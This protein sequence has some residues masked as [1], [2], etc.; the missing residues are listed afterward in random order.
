MR[1]MEASTVSAQPSGSLRGWLPQGGSLPAAEW[2]RR[3]RALLGCLWLSA[4][5]ITLYGAVSSGYDAV[6]ALAHAAGPL[7]LAAAASITR[8]GRTARAACVSVGLLTVAAL[9]VHLTG[10][11]I[12]AH[13]MFFVVIVALT[14]YEDWLPF[15]L[16][17][18]YV[19]VHH[20]ALGTA[21]PQ[22]VYN[23]PEAWQDPWGWAGI[24]ALFV[25]MAGAA[26]IVAWRLN[27]SVRSRMR[28]TQHELAILSETD[29]LTHLANRRRAMID[30]ERAFAPGAPESSILVL[31]DL[32]G[33]KAYNDSFGHPA[34]DALLTRLGQRLAASAGDGMG[35]YRLG[36]DEFCVLGPAT[37]DDRPAI[38]AATVA[39]LRDSG[40]AFAVSASFGSVLIPAEAD[41]ASDAMR[42]ADQRMYARKNSSRPT[43]VD[44]SKNV[45]MQ[46]LSERHPDLGWHLD[47]VAKLVEP[48]AEMLRLTAGETRTLRDAAALHDV[49]KVA[50]PDAIL[51]KPEPLDE[52]ERD[53][54]DRHTLIGQRIVAAA[55]ALSGV[56]RIIRATHERWDGA[57]YPDGL[58]GEEIPIEARIIAVCDAYDAMTS[59][60][61]YSRPRTHEAALAELRRCAGSQFDLS[62]VEALAAVAP[63]VQRIGAGTGRADPVAASAS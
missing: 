22:E 5:A 63:S 34:G 59:E 6:H 50:I 42:L 51:N 19:L 37:A 13:F 12:E 39:A 36:G 47:N 32:D 44:Q 4:I 62:V 3:H 10:G 1:Y 54:I 31:F 7:M 21:L 33:F 55:P 30:L 8:I 35:T 52:G 20:G 17:V 27:E 26:G 2:N 61:P 11:L 49:G 46:A 58:A 9:L 40:Q 18:A 43:A 57:G 25:A 14:L 41:N 53:F 16:A 38:E 28:E 29:S 56:G 15:L 24:H 45:L 60:R 23:R 48:V